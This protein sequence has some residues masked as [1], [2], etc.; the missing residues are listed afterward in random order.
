M[1]FIEGAMLKYEKIIGFLLTII[2]TGSALWYLFQ[3]PFSAKKNF[4]N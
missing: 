2:L 1:K 4:F 3:E